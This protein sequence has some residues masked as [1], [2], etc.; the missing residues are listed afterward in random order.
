MFGVENFESINDEISSSLSIISKSLKVISH[1]PLHERIIDDNDETRLGK[2]LRGNSSLV[3]S[4][5]KLPFK[6]SVPSMKSASSFF[7]CLEKIILS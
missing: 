3:N 6:R 7:S 4:S 1:W 5:K 2:N